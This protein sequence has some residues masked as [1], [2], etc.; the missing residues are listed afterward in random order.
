MTI[1]KTT[2]LTLNNTV[3]DVVDHPAFGKGSRFV[4]ALDRGRH[5]EDMELQFMD[6]LYIY[7]RNLNVETML[8]NI[9]TMIDGFNEG[10][11]QFFDIYTERMKRE[12]IERDKTGL[13]FFKGKSGAPFAMVNPG[14]ATVYVGSLHEGFPYA[15]ELQKK[16]YNV[17]VP[18][19]RCLGMGNPASPTKASEDACCALTW[20][21]DHADELEIDTKNYSMWGSSA[22][23]VICQ[24]TSARGIAG[25]GFPVLPKQCVNIIAYGAIEAYSPV[26]DVPHYFCIGDIDTIVPLYVVE[27]NERN[28][29]ET[30]LDTQLEVFH[31]IGHGF[32]LGIGTPAEGWFDRAVD[33][34]ETHMK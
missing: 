16:G 14:G 29:R 7:H 21:F 13:F 27:K 30:G 20:I 18:Q 4:L 25:F 5:N 11:I 34:W 3:K 24:L 23:G 33:F 17:F 26:N 2:H 32:G 1:T 10:T 9:N 22:G 31:N 28:I 8:E 19:Y 6:S 12:Q 15:L